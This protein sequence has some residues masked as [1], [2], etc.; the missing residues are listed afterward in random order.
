MPRLLVTH[1]DRD[2]ILSGALLLRGLSRYGDTSDVHILLAQGCYLVDELEE[3]AEDGYRFSRILF[4]DIYFHPPDARRIVAAIERLRLPGAD[5][6]W[7][8]HHPSSA[9]NESWLRREL[10]LTPRSLIISDRGKPGYGG[11]RESVS[12]VRQAFGLKDRESVRL[13]QVARGGRGVDLA[14]LHR[15][16]DIARWLEAIDGLSYVPNHPPDQAAALVREL[17]AGFSNPPPDHVRPLRELARLATANVGRALMDGRFASFPTVDLGRGT[18]VDLRAWYPVSAYSLQWE[19]FDESH[20]LIDLFICIESGKT[21]H[22]VSGR[23]ARRK[24]DQLEGTGRP[25]VGIGTFHRGSSR[26]IR[27]RTRRALDLAGLVARCPASELVN[28]VDA[29][30]YLVKAEWK[31]G[32]GECEKDIDTLCREIRIAAQE[33]LAAIAWSD[34]DRHH[35]YRRWAARHQTR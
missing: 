26:P 30:P 28:W 21:M 29:H 12:I 22:Y 11:R 1:T 17:A 13:E 8:D 19:L 15:E 4:T 35:P 14:A 34:R 16:P 31:P 27:G 33:Y 6:E 7:F 24:R 10:R 20:G 32:A 23:R 5:V 2:G 3:L 25:K 18:I 9:E